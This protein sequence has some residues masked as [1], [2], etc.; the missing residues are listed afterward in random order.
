MKWLLRKKTRITIEEH[1]TLE[2]K[3]AAVLNAVSPRIEF[4]QELQRR[5][6][7]EQVML[8]EKRPSPARSALLVA[9]AVVSGIMLALTGIRTIVNL[10]AIIGLMKG[11]QQEVNKKREIA[12]R[13]AL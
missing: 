10:I 6:H 4:V 7:A 2:T 3:L 13:P 8:P 5:L 11:V 1:K 12:P 9:A